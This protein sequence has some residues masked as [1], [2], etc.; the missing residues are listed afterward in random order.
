MSFHMNKRIG[1]G[2]KA[3]MSACCGLT[4]FFLLEEAMKDRGVETLLLTVGLGAAT[5]RI[6]Y[7]AFKDW[8]HEEA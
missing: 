1:V 8:N 4:T 5:V 2:A 6:G 7:D 3:F